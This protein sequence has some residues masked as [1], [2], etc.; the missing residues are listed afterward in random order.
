MDERRLI[1]A[2]R[3]VALNPARALLAARAQDW[4]WSSVRAHLA[5]AGRAE[6]SLFSF[7]TLL[8]SS[9]SFK[10]PSPAR[11]CPTFRS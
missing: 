7:I 10:T 2:A 1:A 5:A 8:P 4:R 3:Y 6:G 9:T 11:P